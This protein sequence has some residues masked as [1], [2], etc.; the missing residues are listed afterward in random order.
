M[1]AELLRHVRIPRRCGSRRIAS[2]LWGS[3]VSAEY[4]YWTLTPAVPCDSRGPIHGLLALVSEKGA[5]TR[6]ITKHGSCLPPSRLS[7]TWEFEYQR[8][9]EYFIYLH[10][11]WGDEFLRFYVNDVN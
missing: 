1:L 4:R 3:G 5:R 10:T 11:F 7:L 6:D 9:R 2:L 8:H